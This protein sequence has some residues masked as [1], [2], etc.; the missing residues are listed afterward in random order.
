MFDD[1]GTNILFS[2]YDDPERLQFYKDNKQGWSSLHT[3]SGYS[4][5]GMGRLSSLV[6]H[7]SKMGFEHLALTDHGLLVGSVEFSKLC[8][9]N[10]IK[11][12]FGNEMYLSYGDR[13]G[14]HI[15]VIAINQEGWKN[16]VKLNNLAYQHG[17][18]SKTGNYSLH[19]SQLL[20]NHE[21][22]IVT[23]GCPASPFHRLDEK[24]A[25]ELAK[26]F[27][28]VFKERFFAE[29]MFTSSASNIANHE[30]TLRFAKD[31]RLPL[32]FTNDVH[33]AE[34]KHSELHRTF[35]KITGNADYESGWLYLASYDDLIDR[36]RTN[37]GHALVDLTKE[38]MANSLLI[39]N[40]V[41]NIQVTHPPAM[42]EIPNAEEEFKRLVWDNWDKY[43]HKTNDKK[44]ELERQIKVIVDNGYAGYHL[45]F[46]DIIN[47]ARDGKI[48]IGPARGSAAGSF[49]SYL[50]GITNVDPFNHDLYFDRFLNE[51]RASH[52][53]P[54]I[55]TD[56]SSS[57]RQIVLDYANKKYGAVQVA[58]W[59]YWHPKSLIRK[60]MS[61]FHF[62]QD[63]IN[64]AAEM[65]EGIVGLDNLDEIYSITEQEPIKG[66]FEKIPEMGKLF[67][68]MLG[69]PSV[70]SRHAGGIGIFPDDLP[71]PLI[72]TK[73]GDDVV[74]YAKNDLE[75][76][77]GVKFD[78]LGL[79]TLD[80]LEEL[81]AVEGLPDALTINDPAIFEHIHNDDYLGVFQFK[82]SAIRT[83]GQQIKPQTL[84]EVAVI[85]ALAR[86]AVLQANLHTEYVNV[87][88]NRQ[89]G[90]ID[91]RK[92]S[93][94][95]KQNYTITLDDGRVITLQEHDVVVLSD[96]K[97]KFVKD[98]EE[99]DDVK[100]F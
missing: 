26:R 5:D 42:P 11:P 88:Q 81:E 96:G 69:Q 29:L 36:V 39:A 54:D 35:K 58:A 79:S 70:L 47:Y 89:R 57:G 87:K 48:A 30:R 99:G 73:N 40:K 78:F 60:L 61:H 10:N 14:M 17:H 19:V 80:I 31:L 82:G 20:K 75:D 52:S 62:H 23:T 67:R 94:E 93:M 32:V 86:P 46:Y 97:R 77:G 66:A 37:F 95:S 7:A 59:G 55:D 28:S 12:I 13:N 92:G 76:A 4:S 85:S 68:V 91:V 1:C 24:D 8:K 2:P 98:L 49:V 27:K 90:T 33:Y 45:I 84:D 25:L 50:L 65:F 9:A 74:A 72:R 63:E 53:P 3:H 18:V 64:K 21:G 34:Q 71:M 38:A 44:T 15:T 51:Q 43:P 56:I 100:E 6:E 22:L 83:L 16:L 41:D